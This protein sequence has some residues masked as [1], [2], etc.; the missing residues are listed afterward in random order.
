M[1]CF[2]AFVFGRVNGVHIFGVGR[3]G[4]E[5]LESQNVSSLEFTCSIE[6]YSWGRAEIWSKYLSHEHQ[7]NG[8]QHRYHHLRGSLWMSEQNRARDLGFAYLLYFITFNFIQSACAHDKTL[9]CLFD[10][11]VPIQLSII[12][13]KNK[14]HIWIL[15]ENLY[16][17][18]KNRATFPLL[19]ICW[20][21]L[22]IIPNIPACKGGI[23]SLASLLESE[24]FTPLLLELCDHC[25]FP[26]LDIPCTV[27]L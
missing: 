7:T 11:S 19:L 3:R 2:Y 8:S 17:T 1:I 15:G 14:D 16:T 25:S 26:L 5:E 10:F 13:N 23:G 27:T 12:R 9:L 18:W 21:N 4:R 20:S 6:D 24:F 22:H